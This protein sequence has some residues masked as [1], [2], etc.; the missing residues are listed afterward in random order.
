MNL[1][2]KCD[3]VMWLCDY[4]HHFGFRVGTDCLSGVMLCEVSLK[5]KLLV[6]LPV[7][8]LRHVWLTVCKNDLL[9][10]L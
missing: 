6:G 3:L 8:G 4:T 1:A 10:H 7:V 9:S 2:C 5:F